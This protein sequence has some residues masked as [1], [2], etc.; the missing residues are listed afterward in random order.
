M[1]VL[2][3]FAKSKILKSGH[4]DLQNVTHSDF[5]QI[6]M[7]QFNF[8]NNRLGSSNYIRI[9]DFLK[10][11]FLPINS[12][13]HSSLGKTFPHI[14]LGL[15]DISITF[16]RYIF[17]YHRLKNKYFSGL[18]YSVFKVQTY[19]MWLAHSKMNRQTFLYRP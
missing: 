19:G 5:V 11:K 17:L 4:F 16:P 14:I 2:R 9:R 6:L 10:L 8:Q 15:C 18:H 7:Y 12:S 1:I 13:F 3:N